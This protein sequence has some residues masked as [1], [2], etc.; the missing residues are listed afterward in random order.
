MRGGRL[1]G[2]RRGALAL[3]VAAAG[4]A[5]TPGAA[6]AA[7]GVPYAWGDNA[8]GQLGNGTTVDHLAPQPVNVPADVTA[9][10]GG[11]GHVLALRAGG[12]VLAW[13]ANGM[14]QIGDG[15][16]TN[17]PTAVPVSGLTGVVQVATGHYHSLALLADGS[18][19]AWGFNSLGQLGD[20]TTT[21][22]RTPVP[23]SG[24]TQVVAVAGGRDMSYALR[25]DGT[26]WA[27]GQNTLGQLGDGTTTNRLT[28][29]RVGSLTSV[30]A[31]AGGR[32]HGL[33]VRSDGTVWAWGHNGYG[34]VGDG[35]TTNRLMPVQ[36]GGVSGVVDVTAGAHHSLALRADG[37]VWSWGRNNLGQLGDGT[38]TQRRS[39]VPVTGVGGA[40]EI[41]AGRDQSL[42]VLGD[43]TVRAWGLN[44]FGQL[45]D[46]TTTNRTVPVPVQALSGVVE[47]G[48]GRDYSVA[49]VAA[50]PDVDPPTTPGPPSGS[51]QGPG[52]IE[53]SWAPSVDASPVSY[54]VFR[55]GGPSP[56][57]TTSTT[58]FADTGL[59]PEST[60]TYAVQAVD[61]AGNESALSDPSDP[62]TVQS[63]PAAI[64][65]D[66]FSTGDFSSWT[67][68]TRLTIATTAGA[69][70]PPSARAQVTSQ[71]A[72][73][74][75]TL[76]GTYPSICA[77]MAVNVSSRTG[78]LVLIRLRTAADGPVARIFVSTSGVLALRSDVSGTTRSS[79]IALGSGWHVVELC[80]T[81][82]AAGSWDL[83]RD[84]VRI[85]TGWVANTG[86][87]P[88]GRIQIGDTGT[89]T[90]TASFDDV[91]VDQAPG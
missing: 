8:L 80:G 22:R 27:W 54:R 69:T 41:G 58:T 59:A 38:T 70:A 10:E 55:D 81:V 23:V 6:N 68:V 67:G 47:V 56:V 77:G 73:A 65:A 30:V 83:Y 87:V 14:G 33:A 16:T 20:G 34:Q 43:G 62:I 48:G 86:T 71:S 9:M 2:L 60:H 51:S 66:D 44:D 75:R 50:N 24:L 82:G 49:L 89:K 74:Y 28:P 1:V 52:T 91:V 37:T 76:G 40:L 63:G 46:G 78:D 88:V 4:I 72:F 53:I 64:F 42:A 17:R 3:C 5:A 31:I 79:G 19:R 32:D 45:G 85:V 13:G 84:G 18:V 7:T 36:V 29:V 15:T 57:G 12:T 90:Y 11:R 25:A 26:V 21:N 35:T 61:S 39:P